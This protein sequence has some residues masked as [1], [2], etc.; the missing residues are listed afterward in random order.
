MNQLASRAQINTLNNVHSIYRDAFVIRSHEL[1][2]KMGDHLSGVYR[3]NS[4]SVKSFKSSESGE[5]QILGFYMA[6]DLFGLDALSDGIS[7]SSAVVLEASNI[8]LLPFETLLDRESNI[9]Y[10]SFI[11]QVGIGYNRDKD[12]AMILSHCTADRRLAWFLLKFSD[13]LSQR[14]YSASELTL[15]M[16]RRDIALYLGVVVETLSRVLTRF[17]KKGLIRLRGHQR[18]IEILEID[19][20][21]R[22]V[23]SCKNRK[24]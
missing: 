11:K 16:T 8:T 14:G 5:E 18:S 19:T 10:H 6:G 2:F 22:M 13:D 12:H 4:G 1:L 21:R 17:C 23:L 9:D 15:P 3:V 20:L 7:R 24:N